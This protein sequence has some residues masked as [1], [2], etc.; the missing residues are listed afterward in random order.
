VLLDSLIHR[1]SSQLPSFFAYSQWTAS[2]TLKIEINVRMCYVLPKEN[3]EYII[4]G[5]LEGF[6]AFK[7]G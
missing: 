2:G 1:H 5:T 4:K 3:R 6:G 7:L